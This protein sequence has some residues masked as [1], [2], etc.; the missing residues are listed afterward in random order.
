[1]KD[2]V[3]SNPRPALTIENGGG[4]QLGNCYYSSGFRITSTR[5]LDVEAI[6]GLRAAGFL[7][8]GQEFYVRG[9]LVDGAHVAVPA[10]L[11]WQTSP[12]VPPSGVDQIAPTVRDRATGKVLDEPPVNEYTGEPITKTVEGRYFVYVVENRV[13]SSD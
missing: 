4:S 3:W 13:D 9:Q 6:K 7:G 8:Y 10:K 12:K 11:D 2:V 5:P 1:M